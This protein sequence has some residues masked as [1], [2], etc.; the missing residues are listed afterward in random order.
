MNKRI[1]LSESQINEFGLKTVKSTIDRVKSRIKS[2]KGEREFIK[3]FSSQFKGNFSKFLAKDLKR[4]I[5]EADP[6]FERIESFLFDT[7]VTSMMSYFISKTFGVKN[8]RKGMGISSIFTKIRNRIPLLKKSSTGNREIDK[9][10]YSSLVQVLSSSS[11]EEYMMKNNDLKKVIEFKYDTAFKKTYGVSSDDVELS[12]EILH[13]NDDNLIR[14][15]NVRGMFSRGERIQ[16]KVQLIRAIRKK[17]YELKVNRNTEKYII[18]TIKSNGDKKAMLDLI[19]GEGKEQINAYSVLIVNPIITRA[20]ENAN[21]MFFNV[22]E[23]KDVFK[24]MYNLLRTMFTEKE[25]VNKVRLAVTKDVLS[26]LEMKKEELDN[27]KEKKLK[28]NAKN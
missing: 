13:R 5:R 17:V 6:D 4:Y 28:N 20:L 15:F 27:K 25:V 12:T 8:F 22:G 1:I 18:N 7:V 26:Y 19:N 2:L 9:V 23:N 24:P 16:S 11:V 14:E 21:D 3:N 10:I